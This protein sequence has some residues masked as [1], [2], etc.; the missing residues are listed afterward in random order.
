MNFL[1]GL[2]EGFSPDLYLATL[3][4]VAHSDG[5]HPDEEAILQQQAITFGVNLSSLPE[6]PQNLATLPWA[7][8][9]LVYRDAL[10]LAYADG[11]L[12]DREQAYLVSLADDLKLKETTTNEIREWVDEYSSLLN[13]LE[14]LIATE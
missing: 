3:A 5:L 6:V 1:P 9:V 4:K 12:S 2:L 8:R 14:R 13:R 7:T 11:E 10:M